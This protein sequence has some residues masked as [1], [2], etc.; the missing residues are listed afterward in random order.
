MNVWGLYEKRHL[1]NITFL[2]PVPQKMRGYS[3]ENE[4]RLLG[5][6]NNLSS[7]LYD[8]WNAPIRG[9][10]LGD[11]IIIKQCEKF[12]SH[13]VKIWSLDNHLQG[14]ECNH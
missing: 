9:I 7:V 11:H 2:D 14:C 6:G 3:F 5:D 1:L 12:Q 13:I 8:L 10:G 4:K